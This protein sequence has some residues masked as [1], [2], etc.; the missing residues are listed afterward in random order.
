ME[1]SNII[2]EARGR[3]E[4]LMRELAAKIE[5]DIAT[6]SKFEKGDRNPTRSQILKLADVLDLDVKTLLTLW[7]RDRIVNEAVNE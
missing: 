7:L 2:K 6:V 1:L 5:V 3:K 4:L